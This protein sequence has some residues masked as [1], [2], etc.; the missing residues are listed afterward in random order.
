MKQQDFTRIDGLINPFSEKTFTLAR[1]LNVSIEIHI[2]KAAARKPRDYLGHSTLV[3]RDR[4][5]WT[6]DY[7][8]EYDVLLP[9]SYW[10]G[11]T[12]KTI[13]Q[14]F[15]EAGMNKDDYFIFR[16]YSYDFS[17]TWLTC[18]PIVEYEDVTF[19][20]GFCYVSRHKIEA[21]NGFDITDGY[22]LQEGWKIASTA[23]YGLYELH[24]WMEGRV[25]SIQLLDSDG[26]VVKR[27]DDTYD[28]DDLDSV[29]AGVLEYY[30]K[31]GC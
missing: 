12:D 25:C 7:L 30:E 9:D 18:Q 1:K 4:A 14:F 19:I 23:E 16:L 22:I 10:Q 5:P 2:D 13:C 31:Y 11:S 27:V 15:K 24:E 17:K 6:A 28:N 21:L 8:G 3:L 26:N 29:G 20:A